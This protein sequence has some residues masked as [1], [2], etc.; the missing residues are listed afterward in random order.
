MEP[1]DIKYHQAKWKYRGKERPPFAL[2]T[3]EDQESVWDYPRPPVMNQVQ[4]EITVHSLNQVPIAHTTNAIRILETASPPTVYI[5][6]KDVDFGKLNKVHS[7]SFCEWKGEAEYWELKK[8]P[9]RPIAWSYHS[10]R[11]PYEGIKDY[12]SFYPSR[13]ICVM[14]GERV[15]P[16]KSEFY[17]GWVTKDIVGPFKGEPGTSGW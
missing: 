11:S 13:T 15:Q 16:Q 9:G 1:K 4:K 2:P 10:P 5:P 12:V 8:A 6:P 17:G 7:S 14:N 3:T